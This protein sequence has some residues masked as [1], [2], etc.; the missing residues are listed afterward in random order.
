[1][2]SVETTGTGARPGRRL[3]SVRERSSVRP[4][5]RLTAA[6]YSVPSSASRSASRISLSGESRRTNAL[7]V[8]S[9]GRPVR[10][11]RSGLKIDRWGREG[12]RDDVKGADLVEPRA[13]AIR[14]DLEMTLVAGRGSKGRPARF[15]EAPEVRLGSKKVR[16]VPAP[17]SR[18][19]SCRLA[20]S[21][22]TGLDRR[23][24]DDGVT[25]SAG[26][27]KNVGDLAVLADFFRNLPSLP[28]R[29]E[30]T[31]RAGT[32]VH[33]NARP[34]GDERGRGPRNTRPSL[35]IDRSSTSPFRIG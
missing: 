21:R 13:L 31:V 23:A 22:R 20:R 10:A 8:A 33:R 18:G 35:S 32:T 2:I 34:V 19:R 17:A 25:S 29:P 14:G 15:S 7:P 16:A 12:Q 26:I 9:I 11:T 3:V 30:R 4:S 27:S 5:I 6:A 24:R 28:C 1:M